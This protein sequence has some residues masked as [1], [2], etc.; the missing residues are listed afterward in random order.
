M[1]LPKRRF[2]KWTPGVV[3]DVVQ[4][5]VEE[6][7]RLP[8]VAD[9]DGGVGGREEPREAIVVDIVLGPELGLCKIIGVYTICI[10]ESV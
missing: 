1:L 5:E 6:V 8:G 2:I 9:S 10:H 4:H 3:G 7:D